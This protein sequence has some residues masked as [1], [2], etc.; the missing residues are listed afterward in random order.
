M[1]VL[2]LEGTTVRNLR[3]IGI[4]VPGF[5]PHGRFLARISSRSALLSDFQI[6]LDRSN[7]HS[8]GGFRR[9]V[10]EENCLARTSDSARAKLYKELKGRYLLD[11]S[12]PL[13]EAFLAEWK[14]GDSDQ[15]RALTIF[16]LFALNDLT[17]ASTSCEWLFFHLRRPSSELRIK[18]LEAFLRNCGTGDHPEVAKWT[19]T[20]LT[21]VAQHYLASIRDFG[22]ATGGTRKFS[23]RP[24]LYAAPIRLLLRA[25][26]LAGVPIRETVRHQSFKLLGIA[27]E[28]VIDALSEL[29]R[30]SALRFRIQADIIELSL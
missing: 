20:T 16:I 2:N 23:V 26:Q 5:H 18:D 14:M 10:L 3:T 9:L 11:D 29:N 30:Q 6:L 8:L 17:V 25:L 21:R 15:A 7:D 12:Q 1:P 19:P 28:E 22:L 4:S 13:F 24:A 27:P